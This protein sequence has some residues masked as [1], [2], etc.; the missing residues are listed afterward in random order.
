MLGAAPALLRA[1][2]YSPQAHSVG[3]GGAV[4]PL[5]LVQAQTQQCL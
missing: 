3:G 5:P 4:G 1:R 2:L